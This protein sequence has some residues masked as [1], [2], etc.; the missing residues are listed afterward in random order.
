VLYK[1]EHIYRHMAQSQPGDLR[2]PL[3][4]T[5]SIPRLAVKETSQELSRQA[6]LAELC[7]SLVVDS[8]APASVLINRQHQCLYTLGPINRSLM[9]AGGHPTLDLLA[10]TPPDFRATL[11]HAIR[12][13]NRS[14]VTP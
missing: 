4:F 9:V 6:A 1:A 5:E 7:R 10:M 14:D 2:F 13:S 3:S 8:F 12:Q 11:R